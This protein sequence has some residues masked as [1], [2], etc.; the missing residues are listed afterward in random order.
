MDYQLTPIL[1]AFVISFSLISSALKLVSVKLF[2]LLCI[3]QFVSC[4]L[5]FI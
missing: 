5:L 1:P 4:I 3:Y 2:V